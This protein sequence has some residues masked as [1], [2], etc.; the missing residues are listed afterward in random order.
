MFSIPPAALEVRDKAL[1]AS[2]LIG[3]VENADQ[4]EAA[5]RVAITLK[6]I[7]Q[8]FERQRKRLKEPILEAG[9]QLD[10]VVACA[11]GDVDKEL[12]RISNLTSEFQL[13]EQ[14]RVRDEQ[15]LQRRELERI[16]AQK[17]AELQRIAREQA[18]AEAK[19]LHAADE[20][21][22]QAAKA[23]TVKQRAEA[24]KARQEAERQATEARSKAAAAFQSVTDQAQAATVAESRPITT[25]RIAG[26]I[27]KSDWEIEVVNPW[28]LAKFHPDCVTITPLMAPIKAALN[29]GRTVKGITAR[30]VLKSTVRGTPGSVIDV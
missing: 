5:V 1:E 27:N 15:E 23:R 11:L 2:A 24:E 29:E 8:D 7:S 18:E 28:E 13:L 25:T 17:Q 9:R 4:N 30:K 21:E 16:E 20:A 26:Q 3:Q 22:R 10:R 6:S 19:A 12:S 14:R